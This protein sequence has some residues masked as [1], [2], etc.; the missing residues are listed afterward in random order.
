MKG[1]TWN[2]QAVKQQEEGFETRDGEIRTPLSRNSLA[3]L[4][5][6]SSH[7][8]PFFRETSF[9]CL[10]LKS[11]VIPR[12]EIFDFFSWIF[13]KPSS[14][15]MRSWCAFCFLLWSFLLFHMMSWVLLECNYFGLCF[16]NKNLQ[17]NNAYWLSLMFYVFFI[18]VQFKTN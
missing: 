10:L 14:Y 15:T 11:D 7:L 13:Q 17:W 12:I 6:F 18:F 4:S 1:S 8:S 2:A 16:F 9:K 5:F 3:I